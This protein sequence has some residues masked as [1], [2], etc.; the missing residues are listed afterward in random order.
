MRLVEY[1]DQIS[2]TFFFIVISLYRTMLLKRVTATT[3][4]YDIC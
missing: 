4:E 1:F 3:T 2:Y